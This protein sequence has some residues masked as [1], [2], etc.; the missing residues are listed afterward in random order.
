MHFAA[1]AAAPVYLYHFD[2]STSEKGRSDHGVHNSFVTY[3]PE[4][5]QI[6]DTMDEISGSM[7]AYWTSFIVTGDPNTVQGRYPD[8]MKWPKYSLGEKERGSGRLDG[9]L[10]MFGEGNDEIAGGENEGVV[11][12]VKDDGW[13]EKE[14]DFWWKRVALF[15]L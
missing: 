4:I 3:N 14:C 1:Q 7:H 13:V 10:L 2:V 8:R 12:Q 11:V 6:S 15:E 5:R 9:R